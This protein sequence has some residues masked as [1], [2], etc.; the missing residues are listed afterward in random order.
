MDNLRGVL[1]IDWE[2]LAGTVSARGFRTKGV[3][4]ALLAEAKRVTADRLTHAHAAAQGVDAQVADAFKLGSIRLDRVGSAKQQADLF[5]CVL[6]MD[7]LHQGFKR[8]VIVTGDQDFL[9]LLRRI[10]QDEGEITLIHGDETKLGP[11]LFSF[12]ENTPGVQHRK[13]DDLLAL[14]RVTYSSDTLARVALL[15]LQRRGRVLSGSQAAERNVAELSSWGLAEKDSSESYWALID[16]FCERVVRRDVLGQKTESGWLP[17]NKTRTLIRM[18]HDTLDTIL[19]ADAAV[20]SLHHPKYVAGLSAGDLRSGVFSN[21]GTGLEMLGTLANLGIAR[22]GVGNLYALSSLPSDISISDGYLEPL[23]RVVIGVQARCYVQGT[24]TMAGQPFVVLQQGGVGRDHATKRSKPRIDQ[25]LRFAKAANAIDDRVV[26]GKRT[27]CVTD[28]RLGT[29]AV[30][31]VDRF[32]RMF[33][34]ARGPISQAEVITDM[35]RV[36]GTEEPFFGFD[37]DGARRALRIMGQSGLLKQQSGTIEILTS[38]WNQS[39]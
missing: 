5:L 28:S 20:T 4:E 23:W 1:L 10:Y 6:A 8:F 27:T 2:N 31:G 35:K 3:V 38:A 21:D 36:S 15:E 22:R 9:P 26:A 19:R 39:I 34:G 37:D 16:A 14:E 29:V 13:I 32:L 17:A 7:Y 30:G 25:A 18:D 24:E 33:K 12:L 11:E